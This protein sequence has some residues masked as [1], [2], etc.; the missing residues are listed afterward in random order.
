MRGALRTSRVRLV[1]QPRQNAA[2]AALAALGIGCLLG[3]AVVG[4]SLKLLF[5]TAGMLLVAVGAIYP[6]LLLYAVVILT[7]TLSSMS[8]G[9]QVQGVFRLS[10]Y[11]LD[12]VRLNVYEILMLC[13]L[14]ILVARRAL[15]RLPREVPL[16]ITIPCLSSAS[17]YLVQL[18]RAFLEGVP[19]REAMTSSNGQYVL[20]AVA[21]LW[22]F[23]EMLSDPGTR[24]RLLDVLFACAAWRAVYALYRFVF[25]SG[26]TANAYAG[27]GVKLTLWESG[28]HLLFVF[29]AA[30]AMAAWVTGA[31]TG[32]RLFLWG[33]G[34]LLMTV[35]VLLS[36]RRTAWFGLIA[37]LI[38]VTIVLLRRHERSVVLV[39]GLLAVVTAVVAWS[40]DRF[41]SGQGVIARLFP[42]LVSAGGQTRQGEWA[43]AWRS[44]VE[45][46]I[47]GDLT[48]RR[49][50]SL[51]AYWDTSIV[52]SGFLF[53][54]MKLGL[55]G[56][57]SLVTLAA[58]CVVY[59]VRGLLARGPEHYI[60][61]AAVSVVP[62]AFA[63]SVFELPFVELRV[64][65]VLAI[66]GALAVRVATACNEASLS[67]P[68]LG[69]NDTWAR[70]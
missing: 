37:A 14:V 67:A 62:F 2:S 21:S 26:D 45:N 4:G 38:V 54:W 59:A 64:L 8:F 50:A 25:G 20:L 7:A 32:R 55:G 6:Q 40:Y 53:A 5:A 15:D 17:F 63:L 13:L 69:V 52:H 18:G 23:C 36:Y 42:D 51:F 29:L 57:L 31:V 22:C 58:A 19:Y 34:S 68:E 3:L 65:L 30:A 60:A 39:P 46:P 33:V 12:P 44:I 28:D 35:T 10:S 1:A 24:L 41:A 27:S 48:A 56:L 70:V 47:L 43:L 9:V 66:I 61:L 11:V 49:A 16:W